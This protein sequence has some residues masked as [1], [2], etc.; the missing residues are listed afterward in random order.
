MEEQPDEIQPAL[1]FIA[2]TKDHPQ[3]VK[4]V[5][6]RNTTPKEENNDNEGPRDYFYLALFVCLCCCW[7][8]GICALSKSLEVRR[9]MTR[10]QISK[11]T[12]ASHDARNYTAV[13]L[14]IGVGIILTFVC[15]FIVVCVAFLTI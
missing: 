5:T 9:Y 10:G 2:P 11:A 8:I 14:G 3:H 13:A 1:V 7:P 6:I 12:L 15:M 4:I